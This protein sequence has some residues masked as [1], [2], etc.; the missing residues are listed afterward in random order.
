MRSLR[1]MIFTKS[2]ETP[3]TVTPKSRAPFAFRYAAADASSALVGIQPTFRQVPPSGPFSISA[4]FSPCCAA[5]IAA[6]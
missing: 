1:A 3:S 5:L 6:T 4:V 2:K